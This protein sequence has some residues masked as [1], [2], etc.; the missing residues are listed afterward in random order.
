[1]VFFVNG[2]NSHISQQKSPVGSGRGKGGREGK[3]SLLNTHML[4]QSISYTN[5]KLYNQASDKS[6]KNFLQRNTHTNHKFIS[7]TI[8][9]SYNKKV[10][11]LQINMT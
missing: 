1:M 2:S 4:L 11:S 7:V 5:T 9:L 8:F 3:S 6:H 10:V